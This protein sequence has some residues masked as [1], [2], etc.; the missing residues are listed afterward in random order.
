MKITILGSGGWG[1]A[2]SLLLLKNGHQVTLWSYTE[3]ESANLRNTGENPVLPGIP[4]PQE[5]E[6]TSHMEDCVKGRDMV[7]LATPSFAVRSTA[8]KAAPLLDEGTVL[9]SVAKGIEEGTSLTLTQVIQEATQN[10]FNVVA[11]SGP[12][13][14]EEVGRGIPTSVVAAAKDRAA[15]ELVQDTFMS[16]VFRV[17]TTD[18]VMGVELGAALKNIIAL[19]AGICDGLGFGDNT[20]AAL[21]TRGL[22][23]MARLGQAMGGRRETF[24][25]LAGVGDLMVTC[26]SQHSR[27]RRC[28]VLIGQG[29]LPRDAVREV[30]MVVEGY[31]AAAAARDLA[32]KAN[33][34]MPI[35]QA[36]WRVLYRGKDP[37]KAAMELMGREK[38]PESETCWS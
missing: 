17:Y 3:D 26:T 38:K 9:V 29:K 6:L 13:H 7:V 30:G 33:I 20:K 35:T 10:R 4:L 15:A 14:A 32:E 2:L 28:G 34:E 37:L 21:M 25:G 19:C 31:Y 11:L 5:L 36:V 16:P 18:D 8:T 24:S 27:N 12:S 22:V 23:E 1:T